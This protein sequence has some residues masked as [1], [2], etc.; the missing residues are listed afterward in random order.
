MLPSPPFHRP[1]TLARSS[2]DPR[3]VRAPFPR[4]PEGRRVPVTRTSRDGTVPVP[5]ASSTSKPCSPCESVPT[6]TGISP[7]PP[8][9]TLLAV[10]PLQSST[11]NTSSSRTRPSLATRTRHAHPQRDA[12]R[13][14]GPCSPHSRVKPHRRTEAQ[15]L[16]S[17][18]S[19]QTP[20]GLACAA[21][22]RRLD[23]LG[24]RRTGANPNSPT[25]GASKYVSGDESRKTRPLS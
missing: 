24:L 15:R 13:P 5:P 19:F 7:R 9:V 21:S 17:L 4:P 20:S 10:Q 1:P 23:S 2:L 11:A 25:H 22:R 3:R 6:A 14:R 16:D 12:P 18:D 8:A